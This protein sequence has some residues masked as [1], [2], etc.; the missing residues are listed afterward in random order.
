MS[1]RKPPFLEPVDTLHLHSLRLLDEHREEDAEDE[2][3]EDDGEGCQGGDVPVEELATNHLHPDEGQQDTESVVQHPEAVGHIAQQEEKR[4][5]PH[6]SENIGG[7]DYDR[8]LGHG[9]DCRDGVDGEDDV[10]EFDN[11]KHEEKRRHH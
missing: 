5:Q 11:Q 9:E 4:T 8:I 6:D 10:R 3:A 1:E 2:D 7:V